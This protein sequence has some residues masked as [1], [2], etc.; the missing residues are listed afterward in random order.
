[1]SKETAAR[2]AVRD[3]LI[4]LVELNRLFRE[5][6]ESDHGLPIWIMETESESTNHRALAAGIA[7]RL[8]YI[9]EQ[10]KQETA[11]L[12]GLVGVSEQTLQLGEELNLCRDQFKTAMANFRKLFGDS[13]EAI[14]Q[15]S[16]DLRDGLLGGLQVKHLHF[17]Q[18]YRQLKLFP[19]PPR[20]VGFSWAASHSGTVRLTAEEAIDHFR[21][22]YIASVAVNEDIGLLEKMPAK[23]VVVIKRILA[24]HLRAN[25]TWP[26]DIQALRQADPALKKQYPAQI[27]SPLPLFIQ[28]QPGEPLPEFNRIRPYDPSAR[29]ERLQRSDA[30]LV[31]INDNP[32]SRI[33]RYA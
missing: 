1:M 17:V 21:K 22:K 25:I 5:A 3:A 32:H 31:K 18:C 6:I 24:P 19:E 13:I 16:D 9:E 33:Y 7:T 30:R 12:T 4:Q 26:K 15:A 8:T 29:Q 10:N 20:R 23:E 27:N 2:I 11:R 28:L 14:E